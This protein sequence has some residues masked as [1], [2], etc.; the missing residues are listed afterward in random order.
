MV[1]AAPMAERDP[2]TPLLRV[3][4][5]GPFAIHMGG[6]CAGPWPRRSAKRL[7]ALVC[8]SPKRRVPQGGRVRR[9]FSGLCPRAAA[10]ALYTPYHPLGRCWRPGRPGYGSARRRPR[11][12][13]DIF[14]V[15]QS[16]STSTRRRVHP[17]SAWDGARGRPGHGVWG[18]AVRNGTLRRRAVCRWSLPSCDLELSRQD[19]RWSCQDRFRGYAGPCVR[20]HRG[21]GGGIFTTWRLKKLPSAMATY[22]SQGQWSASCRYAVAWLASRTGPRAVSR[23]EAGLRTREHQVATWRRSTQPARASPATCPPARAALSAA[24]RSRQRVLARALFV[25]L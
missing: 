19:A 22:A 8:L 21:L 24:R 5:L 12:L 15:R 2:V 1:V 3:Q 23:L 10:N 13:S 9:P 16:R 6:K 7:L 18:R 25:C 4:L 14:S 11:P 20:C 17:G